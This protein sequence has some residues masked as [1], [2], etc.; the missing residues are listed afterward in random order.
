[1]SV[2]FVGGWVQICIPIHFNTPFRSCFTK[3]ERKPRIFIFFNQRSWTQSKIEPTLTSHEL[4]LHGKYIWRKMHF[5]D[6]TSPVIFKKNWNYLF[7]TLSEGRSFSLSQL[8]KKAF[9]EFNKIRPF[10][11]LFIWLKRIK[12][13]YK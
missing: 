13:S 4:Y 10:I 3:Y 1:M 8:R 11:I 12:C 2:T 9:Y 7:F 5:S 6:D